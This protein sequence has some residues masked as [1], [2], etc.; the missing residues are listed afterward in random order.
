MA[1]LYDLYTTF[2]TILKRV[3]DPNACRSALTWPKSRWIYPELPTSMD[4]AYPRITIQFL[5]LEEEPIAASGYIKDNFNSDDAVKSKVEGFLY[6]VTMW[7]GV[8][9]KMEVNQDISKPNGDVISPKNGLLANLLFENVIDEINKGTEEISAIAYNYKAHNKSFSLR[10]EDDKKRIINSVSVR[11]PILS[12][13]EIIY[14]DATKTKLIAEIERNI[15]GDL[16]WNKSYC[17]ITKS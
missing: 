17:Q 13:T 9:V 4:K 11:V 2:E 16:E 14:N 10:Y 1:A 15:T 5:N 6:Y 12:E 8:F 3:V 7:I